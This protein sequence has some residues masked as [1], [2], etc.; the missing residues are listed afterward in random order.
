MIHGHMLVR[1]MNWKCGVPRI[2]FPKIRMDDCLRWMI[3]C[4]ERTVTNSRKPKIENT[5]HQFKCNRTISSTE[6]KETEIV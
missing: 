6:A 5:K 2:G 4:A 1:G 3:V